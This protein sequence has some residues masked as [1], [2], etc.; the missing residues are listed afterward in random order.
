M[1]EANE[2]PD[3]ALRRELTEE[4]GLHLPTTTAL[5]LLVIDW[6]APH[7]TWDD[8]IMMIFDG[9][10]LTTKT[11]AALRAAD[12]E[13]DGWEFVTTEEAQSR[14]KPYYWQRVSAAIDAA[15]RGECIYR[16]TDTFPV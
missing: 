7:G 2:A 8:S 16:R 5:P 11:I 3:H 9:G 1:C 13:L 6:I 4:L 14:L 10:V 12:D 15:N